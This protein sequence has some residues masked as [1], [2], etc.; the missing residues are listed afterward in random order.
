MKKPS[1]IKAIH[2]IGFAI[3]FFLS[4]GI[5][6]LPLY[7]NPESQASDTCWGYAIVMYGT[8]CNY[9]I[10]CPYSYGWASPHR[11]CSSHVS[12][13]F[14]NCRDIKEGVASSDIYNY[15]QEC[16][17]KPCNYWTYFYCKVYSFREADPQTSF[18]Y[19]CKEKLTNPG[20]STD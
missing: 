18:V 20:C 13:G 1:H 6:G 12:T 3:L 10:Q 11:V 5:L 9:Q 2:S 7:F 16:I 17:T 19:P 15:V 14:F 8:N 4:A